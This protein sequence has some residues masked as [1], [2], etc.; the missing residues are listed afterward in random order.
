MKK[1]NILIIDHG[2]RSGQIGLPYHYSK[3]GH[4]VFMIKPSSNNFDWDKIPVW[5]RMLMKSKPGSAKRNF[6]IEKLPNYDDFLYGEDRF[7]ISENE[8]LLSK[9]YEEDVHCHLIEEEDLVK[10]KIDAVHTTDH[11][12]HPPVLKDRLSWMK[13]YTPHSKWI[14]SSFDPGTLKPLGVTPPNVCRFLPAIYRYV[15]RGVNSCNF[16]RHRF[17]FDLLGVDYNLERKR[18]D[19]GSFNH[20]FAVRDPR[21]YEW[22]SQISDALKKEVNINLVNYGA[23][24]RAH[25]ADLK[26]D[27]KEGITGKL[28]TLSPRAAAEKYTTLRSVVHFKFDDWAGGVSAYSR[29]SRTPMVIF[30]QWI[31]NTCAQDVWIPGFNCI[32][33][34]NLQEAV[35]AIIELNKN[36]E[37]VKI[38]SDG[39]KETDQR[40]FH[41]GYWDQFDNMLQNL[42]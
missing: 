26:Y 31:K 4:K 10:I 3:L 42:K 9:M 19:F 8:K 25:G 24:V 17:E 35:D 30:N 21:S 34:D 2:S 32:G 18:K 20:N 39:V 36:D 15:Y 22:F 7:L 1:L 12:A 41:Q 23:N 28:K 40:L 6:E 38:L 27:S 29:F 14:S 16:Y 33:I 5:P 11:C 37:L 13:R